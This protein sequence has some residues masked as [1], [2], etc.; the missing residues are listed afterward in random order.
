MGDWSY[1]LNTCHNCLRKV[2]EDKGDFVTDE[3]GRVV[4]HC[5]HCDNID[6]H[7]YHMFNNLDNPQT[8]SMD[9]NYPD[10]IPF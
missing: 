7:T 8:E 4:F 6:E 9:P 3:N 2:H 5:W 10:D 1:D